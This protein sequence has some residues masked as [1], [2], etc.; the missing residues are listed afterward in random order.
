MNQEA[1]PASNSAVT[2]QK[3]SM[4]AAPAV[5]EE[6]GVRTEKGLQIGYSLSAFLRD[7]DFFDE[8]DE[9]ELDYY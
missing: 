6:E 5:V 1:Q 3:P 4:T 2:T 7:E 9:E 8:V